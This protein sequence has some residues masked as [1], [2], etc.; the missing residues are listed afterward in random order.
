[1]S[2][3]YMVYGSSVTVAAVGVD[4]ARKSSFDC[5]ASEHYNLPHRIHGLCFDFWSVKA[6]NYSALSYAMGRLSVVL[7]K[8]F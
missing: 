4:F 6:S 3:Q 8:I 2:V 1:M 5:V 7:L